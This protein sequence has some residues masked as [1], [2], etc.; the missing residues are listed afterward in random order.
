MCEQRRI[1]NHASYTSH[2]ATARRLAQPFA[3]RAAE[4]DRTG[5]FPETNLAE[6]RAAGFLALLVPREDG[7]AGEGPLTFARVTA[8]LA[9]GCGTTALMF[10]MHN[11]AIS[12][13]GR[14]AHPEQRARLFAEIVAGRLLGIA[15]S[16]A[17]SDGS[18]AGVTAHPAGSGWRLEGRKSFV[19]GAA[20]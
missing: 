14:D 9:E 1:T 15:I 2:T 20:V 5:Q 4:H 7:G 10:T 18:A 12:Q 11:A 16:D 8:A 17:G 3:A 6:L 13:I 19:T